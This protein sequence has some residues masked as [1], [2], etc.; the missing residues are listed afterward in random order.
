VCRGEASTY[1]CRPHMAGRRMNTR[2]SSG[3]GS[4]T[5]DAGSVAVHESEEE[6]TSLVAAAAEANG[7]GMVD[8]DT[9]TLT[10]GSEW[11]PAEE[12]LQTTPRQQLQRRAVALRSSTR[13]W[14]TG[15][16]RCSMTTLTKRRE[17]CSLHLR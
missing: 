5:P 9:P 2:A 10:S 13:S 8:Y 11:L 17:A 3:G 12:E 15:A 4:N 1:S 16:T 14:A 7:E 6:S